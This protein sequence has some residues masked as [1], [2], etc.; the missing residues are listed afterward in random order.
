MNNSVPMV[1]NRPLIARVYIDVQ[2]GTG[3]VSGVTAQLHAS[4]N[5]A[6]LDDSPISPFNSGG[7]INAP[8]SRRREQIDDTLNFQ[9]PAS[10]LRPGELTLWAEVDPESSVVESDETDNRSADF[11]LTFTTVSGPKVVLIPIAYQKDGKG[12]IYRPSL[13]GN[14]NF[15]L[16]MLQEIYPID[17]VQYALHSEYLFKGDMGTQN[18]WLQLLSEINQLRLQERPDEPLYSATVMPKYYGVLPTEASYYGGLAYKPGTTGIGLVDENDMAAHEIG[19]NL[20]LSHVGACGS[21]AGP[22]SSYPYDNGTVGNVGM[23]VYTQSLI[24]STHYDVM[25]YCRPKWISD[26]HYKKIR[27]V[28]LNVSQRANT[29]AQQEALLVSGRINSDG[30]SGQLNHAIPAESNNVVQAP[31]S[32]AYRIELRDPENKLLFSYSF[33]PVHVEFIPSETSRGGEEADVADFGF[34][35]PRVANLGSVQ[36]WKGKTSLATLNASPIPDITATFEEDPNDS[37]KLTISWQATESAHINLR[38]SPDNGQTWQILAL[39]LT[40]NSF[41]V[42]KSQLV[43][44][45]NGLIEVIASDT[46]ESRTAGLEVGEISNKA[47][48]VEILG[49]EEEQTTRTIVEGQPIV[50]KGAAVDFEDGNILEDKMNWTVSPGNIEMTGHTLTIVEGLPRGTYTITLTATDNDGNH[51]STSVEVIAIPS[52]VLYMPIMFY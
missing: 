49:E 48:Q 14:N 35:L 41:T 17:Q 28:L 23:N 3:T 26:Y 25:A 5:G 2:N 9:L 52:N 12:P 47:P 18:G 32:G 50:L 36:L 8:V 1:A 20:A 10:W 13:N 40:G 43:A 22:D 46:T 4:R 11:D 51:S 6:E 38:Y 19:H 31:G 7:T 15:G 39:E 33:D 27:N 30:I 37:D 16:G 42:S 24:D 45:Q 34:A 21:P 44:S 29:Q